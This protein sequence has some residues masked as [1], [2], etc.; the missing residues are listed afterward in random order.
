MFYRLRELCEIRRFADVAVEAQVITLRYVLFYFRMWSGSPP[1]VGGDDVGTVGVHNHIVIN[2]KE[3]H[4][5]LAPDQ[6]GQDAFI[7]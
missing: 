1:T 4:A 3:L 7:V 6:V 5:R 2:F